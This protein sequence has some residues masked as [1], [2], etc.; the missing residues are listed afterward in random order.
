MILNRKLLIILGANI[1]SIWIVIGVCSA[2]LLYR[3]RSESAHPERDATRAVAPVA[4]RQDVAADPVDTYLREAARLWREDRDPHALRQ[5]LLQTSERLESSNGR[6]LGGTST[7]PAESPPAS[8]PR[9][10]A[11]QRGTDARP[12]L[13]EDESEPTFT[14]SVDRPARPQGLSRGRL[15]R[16]WEDYQAMLRHIRS[17]MQLTGDQ[18]WPTRPWTVAGSMDH[19]VTASSGG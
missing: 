1:A 3:S 10:E 12:S 16:R 8:E 11:T 5:L 7:P 2:A 17:S 13:E 4:M 9:A 18:G 19:L 15:D 6:A 14:I